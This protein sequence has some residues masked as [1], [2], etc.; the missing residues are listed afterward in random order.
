MNEELKQKL[1][2][3]YEIFCMDMT[4]TSRANIFAN[5]YEI[6]IKKKICMYLKKRNNTEE[7]AR[8]LL[9]FDNTMEAAYR[10]VLDNGS[11]KNEEVVLEEWIVT[12]EELVKNGMKKS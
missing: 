4:R 6:E 7:Q 2:M 10:Y 5:S 12:L 11:G 9:A 3:E 1:R 8:I